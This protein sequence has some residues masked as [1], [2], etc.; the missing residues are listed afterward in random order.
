MKQQFTIIE[1]SV[2]TATV[3]HRYDVYCESVEDALELYHNGEAGDGREICVECG[4]GEAGGVAAAPFAGGKAGHVER[5][6]DRLKAEAVADACGPSLCDQ[7]QRLEQKVAHGCTDM[8]C[9]VCD[10]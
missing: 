3:Y 10:A 9:P 2:C 8:T 6:I 7:L 4:D 5:M 1:A